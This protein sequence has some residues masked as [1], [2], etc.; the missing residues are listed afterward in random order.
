[1]KAWLK[2]HGKAAQWTLGVIV[3][4]VSFVAWADVRLARSESITL[5]SLFPL[6]GLLAFSLMWTHYIYGAIRRYSNE[7]D[8]GYDAYW[9]ISGT[10]VLASLLLHPFLLS[11]GLW[12]DGLGLPPLS[13]ITAYDSMKV[14]IMLGSL[15]LTIF[16]LFEL[17]RWFGDRPWWKYVEWL[18]L[19]G[20]TAIFIHALMLGG[21]LNVGW[22][23]AVWWGYGVTLAVASV[24]TY[25]YDRKRGHYGHEIE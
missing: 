3:V 16:L 9:Y 22:F 17:Y 7:K 14:A 6:F 23:R 10:V 5:Y 12:R 20:M 11:F 8:R 19:L 25:L 21:E 15:S 24:Y 1:M 4:V 2:D 13:Y 18:Q